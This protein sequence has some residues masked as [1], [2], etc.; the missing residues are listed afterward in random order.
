M[1]RDFTVSFN[2]TGASDDAAQL[3]RGVQAPDGIPMFSV[4]NRGQTLF[5]MLT[6][7]KEIRP[8]FVPNLN[9]Q[10][11]WDIH[12]NVAFVALKNG[13]HNGTGYFIDT[14]AA[15]ELSAARFPLAELPGRVAAALGLDAGRE[16]RFA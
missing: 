7:P 10:V 5:V 14:G 13:E 12:P 1:S 8:G 4:D 9:G 3:L 6:Y 15:R 11:L 16:L 2:S